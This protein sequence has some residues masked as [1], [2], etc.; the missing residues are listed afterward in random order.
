[1]QDTVTSRELFE[2]MPTRPALASARMNHDLYDC[3]ASIASRRPRRVDG[4]VASMTPSSPHAH[5]THS[6]IC[7]QALAE[8]EVAAHKV[9]SYEDDSTD[10][11]PSS[12]RAAAPDQPAQPA[13]RRPVRS[14]RNRDPV[15]TCVEINQSR[16]WRQPVEI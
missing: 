12:G 9:R 11:A 15:F 7:A 13:R 4:V 10:W 8:P 14:T 6:L 3:V 2:R 1:M 5:P 16:Q